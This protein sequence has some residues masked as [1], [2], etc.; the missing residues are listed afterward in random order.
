MTW[1]VDNEEK[2]D[3]NTPPSPDEVILALLIASFRRDWEDVANIVEVL[4]R[5]YGT[6]SD[7]EMLDIAAGRIEV[8]FVQSVIPAEA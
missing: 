2:R 7:D 8:W 6:Y 1:R 4:Q 3:A 5:F